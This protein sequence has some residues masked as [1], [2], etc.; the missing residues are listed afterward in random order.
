M[1]RQVRAGDGVD[2]RTGDERTGGR[3]SGGE[4]V[5]AERPLTP[6]RVHYPTLDG[7][8]ALAA[9]GVLV[10][11]VGLLSGYIT[12]TPGIGPYLARMDVGV[13]IFFV[14]SGFLLYRPVVAA[15]FENRQRGDVGAYARRR[16]LRIIP[17]Y[18]VALV[19]VAFV[20]RAPAFFEPHSIV[21]HFLLLQVYDSQQLVGG[22]IQQSWSLAT[23]V[24]FYVFVPCWA[25]LMSLKQRTPERQVRV[26]IISLVALFVV[27][28]LA[29]L[30]LVRIGVA[31]S[32]FAQLGTWLPF[33]IGD[34]VPGMLLAVVTAWVAQRGL[35]LPTWLTGAPFTLGCWIAALGVFWLVSTQLD[36]PMFPTFTPSQAYAVRLLYVVFAALIVIP[37]VLARSDRGPAR[38]IFANR[39]MVW[40]GLV[41]YGIYIWHEAWQD[42]Y[43]RITDQPALNS[44]FVGM[45]AFTVVTTLICAALSWYLVER[46]A[47]AWGVRA[48]GRAPRSAADPVAQ[49]GR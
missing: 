31:D 25:W 47:M 11:H 32:T 7:C 35:R 24:A 36:L 43:L 21:A 2:E 41:S 20:L 8:R 10:T 34:F 3:R 29:N 48:S 40:L 16:V 38:W 14:L 19:I 42:V 27:S 13:S 37:A 4:R 6:G 33:R 23:E 22:P 26:E 39:V 12:R 46:P 30:W 28:M 1:N 49:R 5:E 9:I 44:S 45:M 18:W 15:R 17:A